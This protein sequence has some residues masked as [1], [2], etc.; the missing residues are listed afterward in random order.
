[1]P[2]IDFSLKRIA[3]LIG[4]MLLGFII[5]AFVLTLPTPIVKSVEKN[6][7]GVKIIG[8]TRKTVAVLVFDD[9]GKY[10]TAVSANGQGEFI[11]EGLFVTTG[12]R[13]L[14][15]RT[16]D[17]RWR[18]SAPKRVSLTVQ[19][20]DPL[21]IAT[22]TDSI[23]PGSIPTSTTKNP[24]TPTSTANVV[25]SISA[26]ASVANSS[27]NLKSNQTINVNVKDNLNRPVTGATVIAVI[28]FP[29]GDQTYTLHGTNG[30]YSVGFKLPTGLTAVTQILIDVKAEYK[31]FIS[32]AK[33]VFTTR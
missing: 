20:G 4:A 13:E 30:W 17:G 32:T 3:A 14:V 15:L 12:T 2:S 19:T 24:P 9:Q 18:S 22:T 16:V 27:P 29:T 33:T 5:G 25:Q 21:V 6:D 7:F 23:L 31:G 10:I 26:F 11:F 28:H 8:Q 1:M